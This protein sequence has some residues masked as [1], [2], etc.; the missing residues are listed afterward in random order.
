MCGHSSCCVAHRDPACAR[1]SSCVIIPVCEL[2]FWRVQHNAPFA[3]RRR[4]PVL[5][6]NDDLQNSSDRQSLVAI[7]IYSEASG[8]V[9]TGEK[10]MLRRLWTILKMANCSE[11][12]S[13]TPST[14][15]LRCFCFAAFISA[16]LYSRCPHNSFHID[17][18]FPFTTAL[19]R[20]S[21]TTWSAS[22]MPMTW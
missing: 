17:Q 10:A 21:L 15:L 22:P 2:S 16:K 6:C 13:H 9:Y 8:N 4:L 12:Q 11:S 3:R 5:R 20:W 1:S 7:D 14:L 18:T 19:L